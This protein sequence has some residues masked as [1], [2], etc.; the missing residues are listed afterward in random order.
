V[1]SKKIIEIRIGGLSA[2][3]LSEYHQ[4]TAV[5]QASRDRDQHLDTYYEG[6]KY[7]FM[8]FGTTE[9]S[10]GYGFGYSG[11]EML[12]IK[13]F[14]AQVVNPDLY[15]VPDRGIFGSR[16]ARTAE[17]GS[18]ESIIDR[19]APISMRDGFRFDEKTQAALS[20]W[21]MN[22][23]ANIR[24]YGMANLGWSADADSEFTNEMGV[25]GEASFAVAH[26]WSQDT[27]HFYSE[28]YGVPPSKVNARTGQIR[29]A[30][31]PNPPT[32]SSPL[33]RASGIVAAAIHEGTPR[34]NEG[35]VKRAE[36]G[37]IEDVKADALKELFSPSPSKD[38][39]P[40]EDPTGKLIGVYVETDFTLANPPSFSSHDDL[41]SYLLM[42]EREALEKVFDYYNK[43]HT[44]GFDKYASV[45]GVP[46][47]SRFYNLE[48]I[49]E[50]ISVSIE[51]VPDGA[52]R[53]EQFDRNYWN[54]KSNPLV[55][56][57]AGRFGPEEWRMN[58]SVPIT[59][60]DVPEEERSSSERTNI[61]ISEEFAK[62]VVK[63]TFRA[64]KAR[65]ADVYSIRFWVNK[66][67]LRHAD[68]TG[69]TRFTPT[70]VIAAAVMN[71]EK[72][73]GALDA[74]GAFLED[75]DAIIGAWVSD[76]HESL[77]RAVRAGEDYVNSQA[78]YVQ[79]NKKKVARN[80]WKK[81]RA[82]T[83]RR[84]ADQRYASAEAEA[85]RILEQRKLSKF[86]NPTIVKYEART[87]KKHINAVAKKMEEFQKE[88]VE[89][90]KASNKKV[91]SS[92]GGFIP[93]LDLAVEAQNL[94]D[95]IPAMEGLL[96]RN[97]FKLR[98]KFGEY[99]NATFVPDMDDTSAQ[100][101]L[102]SLVA[103]LQFTPRKEEGFFGTRSASAAIG[104]SYQNEEEARA[105]MVPLALGASDYNSHL[106]AK[107]YA[108]SANI[109]D[110][111]KRNSFYS[112]LRHPFNNPRTMAYLMQLEEMYKYINKP[113]DWGASCDDVLMPKSI[114]FAM[115]FTYP[116]PGIKPRSPDNYGKP[117]EGPDSFEKAALQVDGSILKMMGEIK[118]A[119]QSISERL[120]ITEENKEQIIKI[121]KGREY[122]INDLLP[123]GELCTWQEIQQK[124]LKKF[125]FKMMLCE[126]AQCLAIPWPIE[127]NWDLNFD[128]KW[129]K[130][131]VFDLYM[132][133][134]IIVANL[135]EMIIRIL[136]SI[137]M[138]LL[139]MIRLPN[140]DDLFEAALYGISSITSA[141]EEY[142]NQKGEAGS[143]AF[144]NATAGVN[145]INAEFLRLIKAQTPGEAEA[146]KR[147][148]QNLSEIGVSADYMEENGLDGATISALVE[149]ISR[150]LTPT[151]LCA[152]LNGNLDN[153]ALSLIRDMIMTTQPSLSTFFRNNT[154]VSQFFSSLGGLLGSEICDIVGRI[155]EGVVQSGRCDDGTSLRDYL[156]QGG[157]DAQQI[158]NAL[159]IAREEADRRAATANALVNSNPLEGV[160][161]QN[162]VD[163]SDPNSVVSDIPPAL[164]SQLEQGVKAILGIPKGTYLQEITRYVPSLY[165]T[166]ARTMNWRDPEFNVHYRIQAEIA[167]K[168]LMDF[169][170]HTSKLMSDFPAPKW[171][172]RNTLY[173]TYL[174][175]FVGMQRVRVPVPFSSPNYRIEFREIEINVP[176]QYKLAGFDANFPFRSLDHWLEENNL[177]DYEGS[178]M[179]QFELRTQI[180]ENVGETYIRDDSV[181]NH[182]E[183]G[184]RK[185][186]AV[187][188]SRTKVKEGGSAILGMGQ[189]EWHH[190]T[191]TAK[192]KDI[193]DIVKIQDAAD[194]KWGTTGEPTAVADFVKEVMDDVKA[195]LTELQS[196]I[197]RDLEVNHKQRLE[198]KVAPA[199]KKYLLK[200]EEI[201]REN[202]T[203]TIR[204]L[205]GDAG[206]D[207]V[208]STLEHFYATEDGFKM[209]IPETTDASGFTYSG[210]I[211]YTE[212]PPTPLSTGIASTTIRDDITL[213]D[214]LYPAGTIIRVDECDIDII[215][216]LRR[217]ALEATGSADRRV[218]S[219]FEVPRGNLQRPESLYHLAR[220]NLEFDYKRYKSFGDFKPQ[221]LQ[222]GTEEYN[223]FH[224]VMY[225]GVYNKMQEV[226][227]EKVFDQLAGSPLF[228]GEELRL[229]DNRLRGKAEITAEGCLTLSEGLMNF[230]KI[231]KNATE[232][233]REEFKR[234]ENSLANRKYTDPGPFEQGVLTALV[235]MLVDVIIVE[236]ALRGGIAFST[237]SAERLLNDEVFR[238][239]I[240]KFIDTSLLKLASRGYDYSKVKDIFYDKV[241]SLTGGMPVGSDSQCHAALLEFLSLKLWNADGLNDEGKE[242]AKRIDKAFGTKVDTL[243]LEKSFKK[244]QVAKWVA[245]TDE[246]F[247]AFREYQHTNIA[248]QY[249]PD[250]G[251]YWLSP[252]KLPY[253]SD[254]K[255]KGRFYIENYVRIIGPGA[256]NLQGEEWRFG[257]LFNEFRQTLRNEILEAARRTHFE[258]SFGVAT[259]SFVENVEQFNRAT[260]AVDEIEER[261][262]E[263]ETMEPIIGA[264]DD[265]FVTVGTI[266]PAL[267][268]GKDQELVNA[269]ELAEF[270]RASYHAGFDK[271][272]CDIVGAIHSEDHE[273]PC[274]LAPKSTYR[275]PTR[276]IKKKR[277]YL[278]FKINGDRSYNLSIRDRA[279]LSET[280]SLFMNAGGTEGTNN[281]MTLQIRT[282]PEN[283]E[284]FSVPAN[285]CDISAEQRG[286]GYEDSNVF[287][288]VLR[289]YGPAA[290]EAAAE[291]NGER[292]ELLKSIELKNFVEK[293]YA[294]EPLQMPTYPDREHYNGGQ[295]IVDSMMNSFTADGG[296][297]Y[298]GWNGKDGLRYPVRP[299]EQ[300]DYETYP[301]LKTG[302][303]IKKVQ[304]LTDD[305]DTYIHNPNGGDNPQTEWHP[306]DPEAPWMTGAYLDGVIDAFNLQTFQNLGS[307]TEERFDYHK[308]SGELLVDVPSV[309]GAGRPRGIYEEWTEYVIDHEMYKFDHPGESFH[310]PDEMPFLTTYQMGRLLEATVG[311]GGGHDGGAYW[312]SPTA[313][314]QH[315]D[316]DHSVDRNGLRFDHPGADMLSPWPGG[317][318]N[319]PSVW[320]PA[321]DG[322]Y[323]RPAQWDDV[324]V[325]THKTIEFPF[326]ANPTI[327][328]YQTFRRLPKNSRPDMH[329]PGAWVNNADE[330][331]KACYGYTLTRNLSH[332]KL[333][334]VHAGAMKYENTRELGGNQYAV[335][336][337]ILVTKIDYKQ[338]RYDDA[339]NVLDTKT[340]HSES[341]INYEL[342]ETVMGTGHKDGEIR[343]NAEGEGRGRNAKPVVA[344]L[345]GTRKEYLQ[346]GLGALVKD[347][348]QWGKK[349]SILGTMD[350]KA[351][352][353]HHESE[354]QERTVSR[355]IAWIVEAEGGANPGH[356][357][358]NRAH[359]RAE[360]LDTAGGGR[361]VI[362]ASDIRHFAR[363]VLG[364]PANTGDQALHDAFRTHMRRFELGTDENREFVEAI[365][366]GRFI[367]DDVPYG[368][369]DITPNTFIRPHRQTEGE[370][371]VISS[372]LRLSKI[373]W[374]RGDNEQPSGDWAQEIDDMLRAEDIADLGFRPLSSYHTWAHT[375]EEGNWGIQLPQ[376]SHGAAIT[377]SKVY[378]VGAHMEAKHEWWQHGLDAILPPAYEEK[379]D[380]LFYRK[381]RG[382][383]LEDST[384][385]AS[386]W[387]Q[388]LDRVESRGPRAKDLL[389]NQVEKYLESYVNTRRYEGFWGRTSSPWWLWGANGYYPGA[390][391]SNSRS[392][393]DVV[394]VNERAIAK[395]EN[396]FR[397]QLQYDAKGIYKYVLEKLMAGG[398]GYGG[399]WEGIGGNSNAIGIDMEG[400][401]DEPDH[402][403]TDLV[404]LAAVQRG[405]ASDSVFEQLGDHYCHIAIA[406]KAAQDQFQHADP[407]EG[408]FARM[409]R[410]IANLNLLL[411]NLPNQHELDPRN[412]AQRKGSLKGS[413]T[414]INWDYQYKRGIDTGDRDVTI[415][416]WPDLWDMH[417]WNP[418]LPHTREDGNHSDNVFKPN[419]TAEERQGT[420]NH[421]YVLPVEHRHE[422][423]KQPFI[424]TV[425]EM[426]S[427]EAIQL[428]P[429]ENWPRRQP[430]DSVGETVWGDFQFIDSPDVRTVESWN[431][432]KR[433]INISDEA[434]DAAIVH[435]EG[436]GTIA[437]GFGLYAKN[438]LINL[439]LRGEQ[440]ERFF[441]QHLQNFSTPNAN[442]DPA[443]IFELLNN[444][445]EVEMRRRLE[446]LFGETEYYMGARLIYIMPEEFSDKKFWA[447]ENIFEKEVSKLIAREE[448]TWIA[449]YEDNTG[450]VYRGKCI[451]LVSNEVPIDMKCEFVNFQEVIATR[452][453]EVISGLRGKS[454]FRMLSKYAFPVDRYTSI[455]SL[456][457]VMALSQKPE[458]RETLSNTKSAIAKLMKMMSE[459]PAFGNT[460]DIMDGAAF[461]SVFMGSMSPD[462]PVGLPDF[463][464]AKFGD[465]ISDL[466]YNAMMTPPWL[467]RSLASGLDP[468]FKD[469][470]RLAMNPQCKIDGVNWK[471]VTK[472]A[473]DNKMKKGVDPKSRLYAPVSTAFPRDLFYRGTQGTP[474]FVNKNFFRSLV[475]FA[476]FVAKDHIPPPPK[477]SAGSRSADT[478]EYDRLVARVN[479]RYG[480][481]LGPL[482]IIALGIPPMPGEADMYGEAAGCP[483]PGVD[484]DAYVRPEPC[485]DI[486]GEE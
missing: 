395:L 467:I 234:P 104:G 138:K 446:V 470:R 476:N 257:E 258:G 34:D 68:S 453:S 37:T 111:N 99:I 282:T 294:L 367:L 248:E 120:S 411:E 418:H 321:R 110:I 94:R 194:G 23:S 417:W 93:T 325:N 160:V 130:M 451:P 33:H 389:Q 132:L 366:R 128:F 433:N 397:L 56:A 348:I 226:M 239:Y 210:D 72:A 115:R 173:D 44:W 118:T 31:A 464:M 82:D 71:Y 41:A 302:L 338:D 83:A 260:S 21:Q 360:A 106:E 271:E 309:P 89:W 49:P 205:Y 337:R 364:Y 36:S 32:T 13:E 259:N 268:E 295:E 355:A 326:G 310:H 47:M 66:E 477:I 27:P 316:P 394:F 243:D 416:S 414:T 168:V 149:D 425:P 471:N 61:L 174:Y 125:D 97:G 319:Y 391:G 129:P 463:M 162:V 427:C 77:D 235:S 413:A 473:L 350:R 241:S 408:S 359:E 204:R 401:L 211:I 283:W 181:D 217:E 30:I 452:Q 155:P 9:T 250:A 346:R 74:A 164:M 178:P 108:G 454:E 291:G 1:A 358:Y 269:E 370:E 252:I 485:P 15:K 114:P 169:E 35:R 127:F 209:V 279:G 441:W 135:L 347:Y 246:L 374:H 415:R 196:H 393:T 458:I 266:P 481:F 396:N 354:V 341:F 16:R 362:R 200:E 65:P 188:M 25:F 392:G 448:R 436:E 256:S 437:P 152:L 161:P 227:F 156:A 29:E 124:I 107:R 183:L 4:T 288:E 102:G 407:Q 180:E 332:S 79:K 117:K 113:A 171:E 406:Y 5:E 88:L 369:W 351:L 78:R 330:W 28:G 140:C 345:N 100:N 478:A 232:L 412:P 159:A 468:A 60:A 368:S 284:Y 109:N 48:S 311:D 179:G 121:E 3:A 137:I 484:E 20:I 399:G 461:R 303:A 317:V 421:A 19:N 186:S 105:L 469:M 289:A 59:G 17:A 376:L 50:S 119:G 365:F 404:L 90:Q 380:D 84:Q 315:F 306:L 236:I 64:P 42:K 329:V 297:F 57:D 372:E 197:I 264:T 75:P 419:Q 334:D 403:Q 482:G 324:R 80:V 312:F 55:W 85:Q 342:P 462:G 383:L 153:E 62:D 272:L 344:H 14:L 215:E 8:F 438:A 245:K 43:A 133:Y 222:P 422:S 300:D 221:L 58:L 154:A 136:C 24:T 237:Y 86:A 435:A 122:D 206:R 225:S 170:Q 398:E 18:E 286:I 375:T 11:K 184:P 323:P 308:N 10:N 146:Q 426:R 166:A 361:G 423:F 480:T 430:N 91:K 213:K 148:I 424:I 70:D 126:W 96:S 328:E 76:T 483:P 402:L 314:H 445:L 486:E 384:A 253:V 377:V 267:K 353:A 434:M 444:N 158:A 12:V 175:K 150:I 163:F 293:V 185:I 450:E 420:H 46:V 298:K 52:M 53:Y 280:T 231:I 249:G 142:H 263:L 409:G 456:Y 22:N 301:R 242:L 410:L 429:T 51:E 244:V 202:Y 240:L 431:L 479:D 381:R 177:L 151:E 98:D 190:T 223:A 460:V 54:R 220:K 339:G 189:N 2:E 219:D 273:D 400:L 167:M 278:K 212:Y 262:E 275:F 224:D 387:R 274:H 230:D 390:R 193:A 349:P 228:D 112:K 254:I 336:V 143:M 73:L 299:G 363:S 277:K 144:F 357:Y 187:M 285:Y 199:I 459:R 191:K 378:S 216:A 131:P 101:I 198:S 405:Y 255:K 428:D 465:F 440:E 67:I 320:R 304:L 333:S 449:S 442:G 386:G 261:L 318:G 87:F 139:D 474:P 439:L 472:T 172:A 123:L 296:V 7:Q 382:L 116:A 147:Y 247:T 457:T 201:G 229:I 92:G 265:N 343:E 455:S 322:N 371:R 373:D 39:R 218:F 475:K 203:E 327:T 165:D 145:P 233:V 238:E 281:P 292:K 276:L 270:I 157:A 447:E 251:E 69:G 134:P 379:V 26:G 63:E 466:A 388:A 305:G 141:V 182:A 340:L 352:F 40:W 385:A 443:G 207:G 192:V 176:N 356:D 6:D 195:R 335:P 432:E 81:W 45:E 287:M 331:K 307:L 95:C 38:N 103:K 214:S 313:G 208:M 290:P